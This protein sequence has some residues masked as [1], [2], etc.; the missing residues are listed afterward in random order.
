MTFRQDLPEN[1]PPDT[2]TRIEQTTTF[3]RLIEAWPPTNEDFDPVWDLHPERHRTLMKA[4]CRAK[5]LTV[6]D[7]PQAAQKIRARYD[8]HSH[9][10]VC[11]VSIAPDS[12]KIVQGETNHY[13]WWPFQDCE[14]TDLCS[15]YE[16]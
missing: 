7:T 5:G 13:T 9:K 10:I 8:Q 12:G 4:E 2:A 6:F 16:P 11:E 3:Y 1:C 15:E 14:P